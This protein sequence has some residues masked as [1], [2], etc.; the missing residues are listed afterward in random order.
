MN[1]GLQLSVANN[2]NNTLQLLDTISDTVYRNASVGPF[3]S[4]IGSHI[5]HILDF[6]DCIFNGLENQTTIDLTSRKRDVLLATDRNAASAYVSKLQ[7]KIIQSANTQ[8]DLIVKVA[9]DLGQ[10]KII[11][12]YTFESMLMQANNHTLHH[13]ASIGYILHQLDCQI[14]IEGFGYNPTTPKVVG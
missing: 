10:G 3:Y 7:K 11:V 8:P 5:R 13:Y 2:L 4:S 6:F 9:D 14:E 1:N 12:N